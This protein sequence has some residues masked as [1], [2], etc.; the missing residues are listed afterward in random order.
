L[1]DYFP[2]ILDI[3]R[4]TMPTLAAIERQLGPV[5][6]YEVPIPHDCT[7]GL[8]GANWR[9]PH[10]YLDAGVRARTSVVSQIGSLE[11]GLSRLRTDLVSGVWR[12]RYGYLLNRTE[13]DVGYRL[14]VAQLVPTV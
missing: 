10:A 11:P 1:T 6:V 13:L 12:P 5:K 2:E 8:L 14:I 3:D 7:D 9:R 4:R